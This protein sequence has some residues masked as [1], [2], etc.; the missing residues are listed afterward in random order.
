MSEREVILEA[1]DV[2]KVF[3]TTKG[4]PLTANDKVSLK[5]YKG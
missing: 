2:T 4:R 3:R 5:T 1:K